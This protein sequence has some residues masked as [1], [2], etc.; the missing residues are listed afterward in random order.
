MP[1]T[2][3]RVRTVAADVLQV[4]PARIAPDAP[5]KEFE[6]WDSIQQLNFV[7]ALEQ[8]FGLQFEPD[9]MEQMTDCA[10]TA[11]LVGEK[12]GEA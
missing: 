5:F 4:K 8:E 11:A 2:F 1:D 10:R 6:G 3:E 7:L 12:L 9:E